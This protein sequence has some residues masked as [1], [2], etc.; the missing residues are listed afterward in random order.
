[1][2]A[3]Q[4]FTQ[5]IGRSDDLRAKKESHDAFQEFLELAPEPVVTV[6]QFLAVGRC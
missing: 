1:L 5:L 2:S 4:N 6:Q 3:K